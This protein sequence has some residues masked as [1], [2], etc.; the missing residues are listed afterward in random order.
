MV[1]KIFLSF[2]NFYFLKTT[3]TQLDGKLNYYL[4]KAKAIN[5]NFII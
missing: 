3:N 1:E 4:N 5:F 2:I